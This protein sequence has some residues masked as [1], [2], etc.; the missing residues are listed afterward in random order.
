MAK[1]GKLRSGQK[2]D[3]IRCILN[4][5]GD[6]PSNFQAEKTFDEYFNTIFAPYVL[7]QLETAN[8]VDLVFDEYRQD[9][10]K[11]ATR[12]KRGSGQRRKVLPNALIPCDWKG[13]LR[14]DEN[15]TELFRYLSEKVRDSLQNKSMRHHYD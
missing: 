15:K 5:A 6:P 3:L 14:V 7:H 2:A 4:Q 9:S 1:N 12:E 10:L 8:R 13:F 11:A